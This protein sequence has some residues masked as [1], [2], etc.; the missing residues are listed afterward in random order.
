MIVRPHAQ[1][2]FAHHL[3]V[4]LTDGYTGL[5]RSRSSYTR[6]GDS[7]MITVLELQR[8]LA[9]ISQVTLAAVR[10][11]E[12]DVARYVVDGL[13]DREIAQ[14]LFLS[15]FTVSQ[16]VKRICRKLDVSSRVFL[17]CLLLHGDLHSFPTRRSSD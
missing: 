5:L 13:S 14:R 15:P 8:D 12:R 4:E 17:S 16:Y 3:D 11:R 9:E 7:A 1:G 10:P 6:A 2:T